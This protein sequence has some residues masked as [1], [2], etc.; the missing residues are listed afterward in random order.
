MTVRLPL[1]ITYD[2][3]LVPKDG[4]E[5]VSPC[6]A[7]VKYTGKE[8]AGRCFHEAA[9]L[10]A[11]LKCLD[12]DKDK[13]GDS[14]SEP[15]TPTGAQDDD[16][17]SRWADIGK[18]KKKKKGDKEA[19]LDKYAT[20]GLSEERYLAT[21]KMIKDAYRD[22]CL[23]FHPDKC[24]AAM[25]D[26]A[27][28]A[29][30]EERFKAIQ[31]S[32]DTLSDPAKRRVFDSTDDFNEFLPT[33]C[34]DGE[35]Y[36]VFG[37]A[38]HR[39]SRW[40]EKTP[41]PQLGDEAAADAVVEKFY[42][43][44]LR[45]RSWREFP[46]EEEHDLDSA[47]CRE[48][49]RY[50]E[51]ENKKL[52]EKNK[53]KEDKRLTSFIELAYKIDPRMQAIKTRERDAR[54]AKKKAKYDEKNKKKNE[55]EAAKLAETERLAAL[56]L[57]EKLAKLDDKKEREKEKK[58]VRKERARLRT[59]TEEL[60]RR[61]ESSPSVTPPMVSEE[62]VEC[63]CASFSLEDLKDLCAKIEEPTVDL[64]AA[65][66]LLQEASDK[67]D[68]NPGIISVPI[69]PASSTSSLQN[70]TRSPSKKSMSSQ[71]LKQQQQKPEENEEAPWSEEELRL[72]GKALR[73]FQKGYNKRW[74]AIAAY[75]GT[76]TAEE[77]IKCVKLRFTVDGNLAKPQASAFDQ[78]QKD[79]K[80]NTSNKAREIE[81]ECTTRLDTFSDVEVKLEGA[82]AATLG[83]SSEENT[84]SSEST[85]E[86]TPAQEQALVKA[87]KAFPKGC[88]K[89]EKE[90]W[91]LVAA[92]V[93]GRTATQCFKH[94][95]AMLAR[96]RAAKQ[97]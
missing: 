79:K 62:T 85:N 22:A 35:F 89:S 92:G 96:M 91:V 44:W 18:K 73:K 13:E 75:L 93:P 17:D 63:I 25:K 80:A 70:L 74:D 61:G 86:W 42:D 59:V 36:K 33:S 28:K 71:N 32:Y 95:P 52:R 57:A 54:E 49:K 72:M 11:G 3:S 87:V 37:P 20:L 7:P 24:G 50:M 81:S 1:S 14:S 68:E 40:S 8:P 78:F 67:A 41:V 10:A 60:R 39:Q 84:S 66:T 5:V 16:D 9:L 55:E 4:P 47:E 65:H 21:D 46:D 29:K 69:S 26:D 27:E 12:L 31:D 6:L 38:F 88:A 19:E 77:V 45:F 30:I 48:H 94:M 53:K 83:A 56:E 76:R 82:A 97:G 90:R 15:P 23:R 2:L 34:E 64:K 51:R 43:F 58:L